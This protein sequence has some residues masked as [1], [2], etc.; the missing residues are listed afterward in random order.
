[1]TEQ[2][3]FEIRFE[4]AYSYQVE[5]LT[6]IFNRRLENLFLLIQFGLG[7]S[8]VATHGSG[9]LIGIFVVAVAGL[10][11]TLK[12]GA[13]AGNARQQKQRYRILLDEFNAEQADSVRKKI[14]ALEEVDSGFPGALANIA[15]RNACIMLG[16]KCDVVPTTMGKL[17]ALFCGQSLK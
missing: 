11:F 8:V 6:E 15:R 1:M 13:V 16:V 10:Q 9:L 5:K 7:S 3:V 17:F 12:P 4:I 2:Q 14:H